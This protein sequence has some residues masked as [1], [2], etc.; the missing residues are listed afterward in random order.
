MNHTRA[1]LI[2]S[3]FAILLGSFHLSDDIVVGI[4]GGGTSNFTG[5]VILA[6][7]LLATLLLEGRRWAHVIVLIG[8]LGMSAVPYLHMT[9]AGL[10]GGRAANSPHPFFWIWTLIALGTVGLVSVVLSS[11][12]LW[13]LSRSFSNRSS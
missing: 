6:T 11:L 8:S 3:L 4:E 10:V 5:I 9:G 12:G 1:L 7:M 2:T 13:R